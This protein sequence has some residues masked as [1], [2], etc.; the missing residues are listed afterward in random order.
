MSPKKNNNRT[1]LTKKGKEINFYK[2]NDNKKLIQTLVAKQGRGRPKKVD[3]KKQN[4]ETAKRC[5]TRGKSEVKKSSTPPPR[6][7]TPRK[8]RRRS[9]SRSKS[10]SRSQSPANKKYSRS[11]SLETQKL[12]RSKLRSRSRSRSLSS[13]RFSSPYR[14]G[15]IMDTNYKKAPKSLL[16]KL[17]DS[18]AE[19]AKI[20]DCV[21]GLTSS[22]NSSSVRLL[23]KIVNKIK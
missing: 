21:Y 13:S 16:N 8:I 11:R 17:R 5:R 6:R 20:G 23:P 7:T 10:R 2:N 12:S 4:V 18:S 3:E 22:K 14:L 15:L 1:T 9:R 19:V